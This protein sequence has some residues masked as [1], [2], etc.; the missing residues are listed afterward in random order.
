M[1]VAAAFAETRVTH[2]L[3]LQ[4]NVG[5]DAVNHHFFERVLH[6]HDRNVTRWAVAD[7]LGDQRIIMWRHGVAAVDVR[8]HADAI[9][10]G[11]VE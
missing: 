1:D 4:R 6:A 8:I 3:A 11:R 2:D 9:A 7:Q 5:L 10:A